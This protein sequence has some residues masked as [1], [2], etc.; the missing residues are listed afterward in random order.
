MWRGQRLYSHANG[1]LTLAVVSQTICHMDTLPGDHIHS[2]FAEILLDGSE[3]RRVC[4]IVSRPE[5]LP[6]RSEG[7]VVECEAFDTPEQDIYGT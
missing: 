6:M 1:R 3:R 5:E 7:G 4:K 2:L